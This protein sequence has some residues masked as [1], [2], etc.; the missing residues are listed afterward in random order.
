M[1][2]ETHIS[3]LLVPTF[4]ERPVQTERHPVLYLPSHFIYAYGIT[5]GQVQTHTQ[6]A[7]QIITIPVPASLAGSQQV[8][9]HMSLLETLYY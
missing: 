8:C 1:E 7:Q 2:K 9:S 4:C 5:G 3:D 6:A